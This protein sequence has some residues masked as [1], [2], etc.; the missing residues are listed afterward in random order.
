MPFHGNAWRGVPRRAGRNSARSRRAG[1]GLGLFT[2][3]RMRILVDE[4]IPGR[5]AFAAHGE[6]A[7]FAGRS[8]RREDAREADALLVRSVTPGNNALLGGTKVRFVGTAT[9]GVD[10]VDRDYLRRAGIGFAS[11]PGSNE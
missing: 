6:V 4:N 10:H 1:A 7:A 5:E 2:L 3:P 9:I 11:A 8:L